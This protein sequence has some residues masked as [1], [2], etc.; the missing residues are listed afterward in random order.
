MNLTPVL[1][2]LALSGRASLPV[3]GVVVD[4]DGKP[5]A[6][7]VPIAEKSESK[8][9]LPDIVLAPADR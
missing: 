5:A 8:V 6:G 2:I 3:Q 9:L 4:S 7:S 1:L